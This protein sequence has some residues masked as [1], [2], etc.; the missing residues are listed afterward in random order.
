MDMNVQNQNLYVCN[1]EKLNMRVGPSTDFGS[2]GVLR[3]G[4]MFDVKY[5][6][7]GWASDGSV[8]VSMKYLEKYT[9]DLDWVGTTTN[10]L[11][12]RTGPGIKYSK[13]FVLAKNTKVTILKEENNWFK[14]KSKYGTGWV[15]GQYLK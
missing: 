8:W 3:K 2:I 14:V 12:V 15:S 9:D 11:N 13:K 7:N 5:T 4:A 1:V 6:V 10:A